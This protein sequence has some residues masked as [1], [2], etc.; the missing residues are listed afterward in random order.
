MKTNDSD[1]DWI[2]KIT[3]FNRMLNCVA[4][5]GFEVVEYVWVVEFVVVSVRRPL[6]NREK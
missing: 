6:G 2:H 3:Q 5:G 1:P 4:T